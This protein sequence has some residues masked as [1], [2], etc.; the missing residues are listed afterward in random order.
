MEY[1]NNINSRIYLE[2]TPFQEQME[3]Y[4]SGSHGHARSLDIKLHLYA[5]CS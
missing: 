1:N 4:Y 5:L 3:Y 2:Y